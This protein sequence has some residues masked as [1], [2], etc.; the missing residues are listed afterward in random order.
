MHKQGTTLV[1]LLFAL[2]VF[3]ALIG[4]AFPRVAR[5]IERF[6]VRAAADALTAQVARARFA[7]ITHGGADLIVDATHA[8][9]QRR[10]PAGE[11]LG[12]GDLTGSGVTPDVAGAPR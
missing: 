6:A 11:D 1:E 3:A 9:P 2:A 7:A 4:Y 12:P 5:T 8:R 10:G